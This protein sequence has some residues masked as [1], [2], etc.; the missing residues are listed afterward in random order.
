MDIKTLLRAVQ[1]RTA[2]YGIGTA[3]PFLQQFESCLGGTCPA[4]YFESVSESRWR[5]AVKNARRQLVYHH[6]EMDF[7]GEFN[8]AA[9]RAELPPHTIASFPAVITTTR[10]DRDGDILET[11]GAQL[12]PKAPLL[13]QHMP[14]ENIGRLLKST[15]HTR[16][17]LSGEFT[18]CGTPL[19]EDCA[20]LAEH[21]ALRI[22][23]GF[24]AEE[25]EPLDEKE[26]DIPGF[27][28]LSFTILEVS[29]VSIPSN[30]DAEITAFSR[31]KLKHPLTKAVAQH[32]FR[33]RP[34][35]S[36]AAIDV[37][38][39]AQASTC[40]CQSH[41]S[42]HP[43]SKAA[44]M[45]AKPSAN[46]QSSGKNAL[47]AVPSAPFTDH[48]VALAFRSG[49]VFSAANMKKLRCAASNFR[50]IA[51]DDEA[52][53]DV[54]DLAGQGYAAL[55]SL[56]ASGG[57]AGD[58]IDAYLDAD[59]P[60]KAGRAVSKANAAVIAQAIGH[61]Q[62]IAAH[63]SAQPHHQALANQAVK[64]L[65]AVLGQPENVSQ[66][67]DDG[68][69]NLHGG[70]P[71]N[72]E[73]TGQFPAPAMPADK[74]ALE[75]CDSLLRRAIAEHALTGDLAPLRALAAALAATVN[76]TTD[77]ISRI[78]RQSQWE[79]SDTL[80]TDAVAHV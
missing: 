20:M 17:L 75:G 34:T 55:D 73:P 12:D 74:G 63:E 41:S 61:G 46:A 79:L 35:I 39:L 22:S 15:Q 11:R 58:D 62:A 56:F 49:R 44:A 45:P 6:P 28:V 67:D 60:G 10:Q 65:A 66:D 42:H 8:K 13:Y 59:E 52:H 16:K 70:N 68:D 76:K 1:S 19:G 77:T 53:E 50:A 31:N 78:E 30:P 48:P 54:S 23:H 18:L 36:S 43:S 38:A 3:A 26:Y 24:L 64:K 2:S 4:K 21:G 14:F 57:D 37:G 72:S 32:K 29:L 69:L 25:F 27:R 80:I 51:D 9:G 33:E 7:A 40:T 5:R 47:A 71:T